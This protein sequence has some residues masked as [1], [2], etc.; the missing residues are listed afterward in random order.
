MLSITL[1]KVQ[2]K[3]NSYHKVLDEKWGK[4]AFLQMAGG[5]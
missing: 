1:R 5:D 4:Q 3:T 2:V